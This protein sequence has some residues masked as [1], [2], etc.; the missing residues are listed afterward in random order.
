[1]E[2]HAWAKEI[3]IAVIVLHHTRKME[4]DDPIDTISGTLGLAGCVD[5][6][7]VLSRNQ[8][9]TTLYIRGRD[10]EEQELALSFSHDTLRWTVLG[11][12]AEVLQSDSRARVSEALSETNGHPMSPAELLTATGL[13]RQNLDQLLHRMVR[14]GEIIKVK[15]GLYTLAQRPSNRFQ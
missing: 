9:G 14:D 7:V 1:M 6:A 12:A 15:R 10:V 4:A 13:S 5:T 3:G 11:D 8:K 2:I